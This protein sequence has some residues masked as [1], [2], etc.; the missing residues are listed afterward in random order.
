MQSLYEHGRQHTILSHILEVHRSHV[1]DTN[2][3]KKK[4][5]TRSLG[6]RTPPVGA[7]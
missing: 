1:Y 5:K 6:I 2:L 7:Y 4:T 3:K